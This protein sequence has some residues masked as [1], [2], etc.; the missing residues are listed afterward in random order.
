MGGA[1]LS[2]HGRQPHLTTP[3]RRTWGFPGSRPKVPV[4]QPAAAGRS[5]AVFISSTGIST[6]S[7]AYGKTCRT[8]VLGR[9]EVPVVPGT[10]GR[11]RPVPRFQAQGA[12]QIPAR[13]ARLRAGIPAVN[14][15]Q[16]A[17]VFGCLVL[18]RAGGPA[19]QPAALID[20]LSPALA[21]VPFGRYLPGRSGSG[22]GLGPAGQVCDG[23]VFVGHDRIVVADQPG[24]GA[25][26]EIGPG[27]ADFAVRAGNLRFG[28]RPV[29]GAFLAAGQAAL[30]AGQ[31]VR[32]AGQLAGMRIFSPSEVTAK[33]LI[34]RSIPA[35]APVAGRCSGSAT[36]TANETYQRPHGSRETVTVV[37]SSL[38]TSAPGH[39]HTKASGSVVFASHS[40][41]SFMRKADRV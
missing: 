14:Y 29:R 36:S 2:R 38:V 19:P 20:L 30:I 23:Q 18:Q 34:P 40:T 4:S 12:E 37:G 6:V 28:F 17:P 26:Q 7:G 21:R 3:R 8:D 35:T 31:G 15:D 1:G 33:S 41:P 27:R 5:R 13:A 24:T 16:P 25:V 32:P 22:L 10:A 39:D 9:V 11:A